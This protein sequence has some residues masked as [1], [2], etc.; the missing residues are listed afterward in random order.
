MGSGRYHFQELEYFLSFIFI[1]ESSNVLRVY[2]GDVTNPHG[3]RNVRVSKD[4]TAPE[5]LVITLPAVYF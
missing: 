5:V 3:W 1:T 2:D 4:A